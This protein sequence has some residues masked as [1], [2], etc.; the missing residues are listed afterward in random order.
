MS[1]PLRIEFAG[2]VYH[3]TSRGDR[4]EPIYRDDPDRRLH[5]GV[6][7]QAMSRF[8]AQ[9]L[10]YCLMGNHY[11]LVLQTRQPNLSRLMRHLNGVYTQAFNRRHGLTGHLF[12]GR[13]KAI[14]VDRD[15]YLLA[16][17]RY[18]E[19]NP[20]AAGLVRAVANWPWSSYAAHVGAVPAEPW[21]DVDAMHALVLQREPRGPADRR[22]AAARYAELVADARAPS[23]WVEGLRQQVFLGDEDFVA[24]TL[25]QASPASMRSR[26]IPREQRRP[27]PAGLAPFLRRHGNRNQALYAGYKEGGLTMTQL[28]RECGLSVSR[29]SR[30]VAS[31]EQVMTEAKGKT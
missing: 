1:R 22:R 19:R 3:V 8:D 12:Q 16:L 15:P 20:V 31:M 25:A 5:L 18:V 7:A 10:A 27:A 23:P 2:A 26:D 13:F 11:H 9:V 14:L 30:V 4:R 21:L 24:R 17:C 29:V 28:A 6:L